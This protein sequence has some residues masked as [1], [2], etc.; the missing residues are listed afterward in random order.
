[1]N[2][3]VYLLIENLLFFA[4]TTS[5]F[6]IVGWAWRHAKPYSLP[7]PLP[8]WFSIWFGT[9]QVVGGLIP[10]IVMFV[11]GVWWSYSSVLTVLVPYFVMLGLQILSESVT[12]RQL[13][14]VVWVMVPYLYVPYRVWQLY[15]GLS[16]LSP[17]N[18]LIW[19]RN[20][21]LVNIV[22]WTLNYA[23][24]LAQLP[25]LLRWEIDSQSD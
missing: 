24:D 13:H 7:E 25:R 11:W 6:V 16:L 4:I 2:T 8:G 1:M 3:A 21:L 17:E 9:V 23:L 10:L 18:E 14:T 12:L 22:L 19:V 5:F 20:L 15:E